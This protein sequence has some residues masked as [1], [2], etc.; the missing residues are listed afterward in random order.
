MCKNDVAIELF[1]SEFQAANMWKLMSKLER[2]KSIVIM[3]GYIGSM[4][5]NINNIQWQGVQSIL[6]PF[7]VDDKNI[8][9]KLSSG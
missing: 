9:N 1:W 5:T 3:K 8:D 7:G 2:L 6:S 4:N